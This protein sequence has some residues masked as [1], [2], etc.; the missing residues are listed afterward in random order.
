M[1][2]TSHPPLRSAP[3]RLLG[4]SAFWLWCIPGCVAISASILEGDHSLSLTAAGVLWTAAT[5]WIGLGCLWNAR[6]CGRV[7]CVVD[8][9]LLPLLAI[10][11]ALNVATV[12]GIS[13]NLYWAIFVIIVVA[14]F[15]PEC[16]GKRYL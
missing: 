16:L 1:G 13:W 12:I 15:V 6:T 14:S 4:P 2:S 11:G 7:H 3:D 8:G 10:V 9:A 5:L